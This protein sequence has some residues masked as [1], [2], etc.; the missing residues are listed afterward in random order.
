MALGNVQLTPQL[1]QAVRDAVDIVSIAEEYTRLDKKGPRWKGLCP[2][3]KE[4]TPSFSVDPT[5]GLYYCFG[6]GA[7]GDAIGLH[8]TLSGEDFPEAIESLA[9]RHGIPLP[10][11][12]TR[13]GEKRA[14]D[15]RPALEAAAEH[16]TGQLGRHDLP[17]S[18]LRRR[19]IEP[20][21]ARR[22]GLGYAPDAWR[23]LWEALEKKF[24][25]E[26]L[27]AAGLVGTSEK[28]REPYDRFRNRLMFPIRNAAGRLVGFGGRTLGDDKAKYINT[29]ET[30]EFH[31]GDL[32]YGLDQAKKA[33][34][35]EG[36]ALLVEGYFDVIGSAAAG[37]DG[38]VAGMGTSLT[39]RQAKL[40]ARY[41]EEVVLGYD[42]DEAGDKACRRALPILLAEGLHVRRARFGE[43][44]D[45]DSLRLE[46]GP[47][48]VREAVDAARDAVEDEIE[49]LAPPGVRDEPR[50]QARAAKELTGLL[51]SI[52]DAVLRYGYVR[53]AA[54]RLDV[55]PELLDRRMPAEQGARAPDPPPGPGPAPVRPTPSRPSGGG[56]VRS[57]EDDLLCRLLAG[58]GDL[59]TVDRW[60]PEELFFDP[61]ARNIY[62][63]LR[64]L[65]SQDQTPPTARDVVAELGADEVA[66]ARVARY[67]TTDGAAEVGGLHRRGLWEC[68]DLM[69]QRWGRER[70]KELSR[71]IAA[72]QRDGDTE[73]LDGLL[74]E[75]A[76][77]SESL[78]GV[79]S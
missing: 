40:L 53:R 34:R 8:M 51:A 5:Q 78:H 1:V 74:E 59:P 35:E 11:K 48:A 26:T 32:L 27:L 45:P 16:F 13:P 62:R 33:I 6:C 31:K 58:G 68:L 70:N 30:A 73:R 75:K 3:H 23:V 49:R 72:A 50:A 22:Y 39:P 20:E 71:A 56:V 12:Q 24:P 41:A 54:E 4:K 18:Y 67:G 28:A 2:I 19:Q 7:G 55:P 46:Q 14:P 52:P 65:Y 38:A 29:S 79:R 77:L 76:R 61:V 47:E 21:L 64:T 37:L 10:T 17:Q 43:G 57:V 15:L 63:T 44:Q 60:P 25:R 42:G 9:L 69:S 36:R 66:V